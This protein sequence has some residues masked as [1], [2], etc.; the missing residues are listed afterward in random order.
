MMDRKNDLAGGLLPEL[1]ELDAEL[2]GIRIEE[3]ASFGPELEA[4]LRREAARLRAEPPAPRSLPR[5]VAIAASVALLLAAG[6]AFPA[7][8]ALVALMHRLNPDPVPS[9][10][11]RVAVPVVIAT[12]P[13]SSAPPPARAAVTPRAPAPA[14]VVTI[15][16]RLLDA[17]DQQR[18]IRRYYPPRLQQLHVGGIVNV[19]AWVDSLGVV[20]EVQIRQSS[21]QPDIDR[22]ALTA[23]PRLAFRPALREGRPVATWVQFDLVFAPDEDVPPMRPIDPA[24]LQ[25]ERTVELP[26]VW[27]GLA[28]LPGPTLQEAS[29][30]LRVAL[31][32]DALV[33]RLGSLDGIIV[34]EPPAGADPLAWRD[35]AAAALEVAIERAP[36]NPAPFL[37]LARILRKQGLHEEARVLLEEGIERAEHHAATV[38]PRLKAELYYE[39]GTSARAAWRVHANLGHVS[40]ATLEQASCP[41][42]RPAVGDPVPSETLIAWNYLCPGELSQVLADGFEP[43]PAAESEREAMRSSLYAAV[44]ADPAHVGA[45]VELLL[46]LADSGDPRRLLNSARRFAYASRGHPYARLLTGLAL[47]RI[48]RSEDALA[49][50]EAGLAGVSPEEADRIRDISPLLEAGAAERF[51]AP[52][53]DARARAEASFWAPLDPLVSTP[54]NE[55]R[56][57]HLAR[58]VYAH[59]RLGGGATDAGN[60]WI[61][62]G[63]PLRVRALGEGTELRTELWEYGQGPAVTLRRAASASTL[64]LTPEGR[65][66]LSDLRASRPHAYG[67][68]G[69]T[70]DPLAAEV[71]RARGE[72]GRIELEVETRVPEALVSGTDTLVL[73]LVQLDADGERVAQR[74]VPIVPGARPTTVRLTAD[75]QARQLA[76]E[77]FNPSLGRAAAVRVSVGDDTEPV[78]GSSASGSARRR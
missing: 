29:A 3:R 66:Y 61:R 71:R 21:G 72:S 14:P 4:E 18:M 59:L 35:E 77:I 17:E 38:S 6:A 30:L 8:A 31:H 22:A 62:Y 37:A 36:E 42:A 51:T 15:P 52:R 27:T 24:A 43:D 5:R 48:G 69:R 46:D 56:V 68:G 58:S 28:A 44:A 57:A 32:D 53:G 11:S 20:G 47:H 50:L 9:A 33:A 41:R 16:P 78:D 76:L 49:E 74:R 25:I 19:L 45:N 26:P 12:P 73:A 67:A 54:V 55:R 63:E 64:E 2:A 1:A 75:G 13:E 10:P 39:L 70:V 34:G 23:A 65:A 7:R 40:A 60:L